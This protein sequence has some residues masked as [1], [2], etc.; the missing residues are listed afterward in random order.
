MEVAALVAAIVSVV[1]AIVAVL[2]ARRLDR[3]AAKA[4]AAA[5]DS[6][7]AAEKSAKASQE[8]AATAETVV[9]LDRDR[10]H[11]DL[12]PRF[13]VTF[14]RPQD[15][16]LALDL[17]FRLAGPPE[18]E[19][20]DE[21]LVTI[22]DDDGWR[23]RGQFRTGLRDSQLKTQVWGPY[24]FNEGIGPGV[25]PLSGAFGTDPAGRATLV[26]DIAV[27]EDVW[28]SLEPTGPP[29]RTEETTWSR[30]PEAELTAW[31]HKQ[32]TTLRLR[33]SCRREGWEPWTLFCEIETFGDLE[34]VNISQ[35]GAETP[36]LAER[37]PTRRV[38]CLSPAR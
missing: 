14:R 29:P 34:T 32:S 23:Y 27:F 16:E 37:S 12:T 25:D 13:R 31:W 10:R 2:Y 35:G 3:L 1:V 22:L 30:L 26:R 24:R 15:P 20:V 33:L 21:L 38:L 18:L 4:I 28:L 5:E 19:R 9:A 6:A 17:G 8:S 11:A 7:A 36:G